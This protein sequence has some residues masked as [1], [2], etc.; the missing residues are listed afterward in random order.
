MEILKM[1]GILGIML[2]VVII[3]CAAGLIIIAVT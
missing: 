1:L 3:M 2:I